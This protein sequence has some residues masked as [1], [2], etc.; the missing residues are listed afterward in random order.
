M[1]NAVYGAGYVTEEPSKPVMYTAFDKAGDVRDGIHK[2]ADRLREMQ[3]R[4]VGSYPDTGVGSGKQSA[5]GVLS[6]V[7]SSKLDALDESL[8]SARSAINDIQNTIAFME[9]RL[10]L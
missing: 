1:A 6:A 7:A 2:A 5:G 4:L 8:E 10:G 3:I 9:A